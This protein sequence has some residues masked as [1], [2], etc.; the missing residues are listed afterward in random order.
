MSEWTQ[1][2]EDFWDG[3][4]RRGSVVHLGGTKAEDYTSYFGKA[5]PFAEDFAKA[6]AVL[7]IGPG[8]CRYL[9]ACKGKWR[10]AIEVSS[11]GRERVN[12]AGASAYEPGKV[13]ADLSDL[14][15]CLSV[16]QHC[17]E[18][19]TKVLIQDAARATRSGGRF[20][21]NGV[22]G[23]HHTPSQEGLLYGGRFSYGVE[24]MLEIAK[25]N[26]FTEFGREV[27]KLGALT[28][29]ILCLDRP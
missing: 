22:E 6:G 26:G 5:G 1:H 3:V 16:I 27:Y 4:H 29:W 10:H 9:E 13:P 8:L 19:S 23:G 18:L 21:L 7:D 25:G 28:V 12:S 2:V 11:V 14:T 20:Y 17:D 24:R 15:T